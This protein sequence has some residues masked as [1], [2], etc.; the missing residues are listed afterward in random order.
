M[1]HLSAGRQRVKSC[2]GAQWRIEKMKPSLCLEIASP[3]K[4]R[5]RWQLEKGQRERDRNVDEN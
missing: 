2:L 5:G 1:R 3:R 4:S